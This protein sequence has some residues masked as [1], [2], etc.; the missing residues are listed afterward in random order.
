M[1]YMWI[2]V[3]KD[4]HIH[5]HCL[6]YVSLIIWGFAIKPSRLLGPLGQHLLVP[7]RV[8]C[9]TINLALAL[10]WR[11]CHDTHCAV[12]CSCHEAWVT[13]VFTRS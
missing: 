8:R 3:Y 6:L 5:C 1:V 11:K 2:C 12:L 13:K 4:V 9:K 7:V 10:A